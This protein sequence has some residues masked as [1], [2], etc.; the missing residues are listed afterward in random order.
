MDIM[1]SVI[2][3]WHLF[4]WR[5]LIE[6]IFFSSLFYFFSL[7][8]KTDR[9]SNTLGYFYSYCTITLLSYAFELNVISQFLLLMAPVAIML[10]VLVHQETLQKNFVTARN[11]TP[12]KVTDHDWLG[13]LMRA[14]L[15]AVNKNKSVTCVIERYDAL[16]SIL[17]APLTFNAPIKKDLLDILLSSNSYDAQ[18]MIW[19]NHRGELVGIN[20]VWHAL[21]DEAWFEED[22]KDMEP[23]KRDALIL[24]NKTDSLVFKINP[25][26]RTC[27]L[28]AQKKIIE[29][30]SANEAVS[31]I[32][33]YVYGKQ[34]PFTEQ[35]PS[36]VARDIMKGAHE[37]IIKKYSGEQSLS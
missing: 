3:Q 15:T 4:G 34:Q 7:W 31:I 17:A 9:R 5:S 25:A 13:I 37:T 28:I 23:W 35:D 26:T 32:K 8:L 36:F 22:I 11:I 14:Y 18:A 30:V 2:K 33:K 24:T 21:V 6:I 29:N 16:G 19:V 20:T 27:D 10:L 12:A 1:Q